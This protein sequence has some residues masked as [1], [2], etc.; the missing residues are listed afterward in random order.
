M[1]DVETK[2]IQ[3][4][5]RQKAV[6]LLEAAGKDV[7]YYIRAVQTTVGKELLTYWMDEWKSLLGKIVAGT[8]DEHDRLSFVVIDRYLSDAAKR[9]AHYYQIK[10]GIDNALQS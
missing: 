10:G 2:L 4:M 5:G 1:N 9:V 6:A 3:K 7:D 8:N